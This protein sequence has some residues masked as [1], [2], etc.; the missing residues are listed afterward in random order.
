[1]RR[2]RMWLPAFVRR[3]TID[4]LEQDSRSA[5]HIVKFVEIWR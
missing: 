5:V 3:S 4:Q 2:A 1:M